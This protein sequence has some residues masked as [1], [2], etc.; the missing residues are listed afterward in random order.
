[1]TRITKHQAK[2]RFASG[3]AFYLCPHKMRPDYLF[4]P[5]HHVPA[6]Y[7]NRYRSE[8]GV[9]NGDISDS[10]AWDTL[11]NNWAYYNTSYEQGYYAAYYIDEVV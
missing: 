7:L 10:Q 3:L 9:Y 1:M 11:Y 4:C 8:S 6:L 2:Q 5:A